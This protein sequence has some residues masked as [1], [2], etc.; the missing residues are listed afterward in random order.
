MGC[1]IL[2]V[3]DESDLEL[4]IKQWFREEI[5]QLE[6]EF[7]FA[8]DGKE[9][10]KKLDEVQGISIILADIRM[11]EMDGL[12][13]LQ[14]IN[15]NNNP[16]IKTIMVSA[17]GDM[18]NIRKAMNYGAFDFITKPIDFDDLKVTI[19][20]TLK[21]LEEQ[22]EL[23]SLQLDM[24]V[25]AHIQE[26]MLPQMFTP[27][28]QQTSFDI[29]PKMVPAKKVGGDFYDF[30]FIDQE[31]LVFS[32][33][34]VLGKGVPAALFMA[35]CLTLLR[36]EISRNKHVGI[37]LA[38]LKNLLRPLYAPGMLVTIFNGILNVNIGELQY[39]CGGH[40]SPYILN[41][42]GKVEPMPEVNGLIIG[43]FEDEEYKVGKIQL[44]KGETIFLYTDG[45][46]D[47]QRKDGEMFEK[48]RLVQY[49]EKNCQKSPEELCEGLIQEIE[50]FTSGE[51]PADDI[52]IMAL[53]YK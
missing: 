48:E 19:N 16:L 21:H 10:L 52:T 6:L 36:A 4:L 11:P 49:L 29:F 45:V 37:S 18:K 53:R 24:Q 9:A 51:P 38:S 42:S 35:V 39:A 33:G 31:R 12:T 43:P 46:T 22:K 5:R 2:V 13:M 47:A 50:K 26:S 3:D 8:R 34:D 14:E 17:Y 25:A 27:F 41:P 28:P 23:I 7:F 40:H 1:K 15:K 30:F 32:I 44:N 20:K